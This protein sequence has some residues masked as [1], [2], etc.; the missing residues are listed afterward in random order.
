MSNRPGIYGHLSDF[1]ETWYICS[2]YG[3]YYP[4]KFLAWYASWFLFYDHK[5][6]EYFMKI[7]SICT[8]EIVC[9]FVK[10]QYFKIKFS[11]TEDSWL[12]I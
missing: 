7:L 12:T 3:S 8:Y 9:N 4:Y 1:N 5:Y 10:H 2:M 11:L 6:F